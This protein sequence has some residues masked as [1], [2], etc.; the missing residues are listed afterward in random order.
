MPG[1]QLHHP[2]EGHF[3]ARIGHETDE[4]RHILDVRLF[5]KAHAARDLIRNP[6]T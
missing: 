5:E 4:R 1:Q 2:L 6:A 3:I